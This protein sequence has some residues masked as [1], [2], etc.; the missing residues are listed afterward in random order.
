MVT[1][2]LSKFYV[3]PRSARF[4]SGL[5]IKEWADAL[6]CT[7]KTVENYEFGK[8]QIPTERLATMAELS[9][10]PVDLIISAVTNGHFDK[11]QRRKRPAN[12]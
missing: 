12:V 3:T 2:D 8:T 11:P 6:G 1:I 10:I 9:H 5:S 7:T 4:N